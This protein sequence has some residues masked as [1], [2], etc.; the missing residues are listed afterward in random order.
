M[1]QD[2][3]VCHRLEGRVRIRVERERGNSLYF[4]AVC[5][6]LSAIP[7]VEAVSANAVTGTILLS[8]RGDFATL[9]QR[10]QEDKLLRLTEAPA[11]SLRGQVG[12]RLE[13][14]SEDLARASGGA[15]SLADALFVALVGFS[16]HEAARGHIT[17]PAMTLAWYAIHAL[18]MPDPLT[19]RGSPAG[20]SAAANGPN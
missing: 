15:L 12:E 7:G 4:A 16:I 3:H 8:H 1:L 13:R 5:R 17:A 18:S 14:L 11:V 19:R 9:A 10:V 20:S 6:Q 2:A